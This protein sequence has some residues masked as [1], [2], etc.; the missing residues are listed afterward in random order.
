MPPFGQ[1]WDAAWEGPGLARGGG[2]GLEGERAQAVRYRFG[3][4]LLVSKQPTGRLNRTQRAPLSLAPGSRHVHCPGAG[5]ARRACR[6][7]MQ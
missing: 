5:L 2:E 7:C 6:T 3:D 4:Y 1:S